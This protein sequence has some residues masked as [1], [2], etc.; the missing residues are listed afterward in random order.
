MSD[1]GIAATRAELNRYRVLE[2][3]DWNK[4]PSQSDKA[5]MAFAGNPAQGRLGRVARIVIAA[6]D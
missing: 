4:S 2:S 1:S 5:M 3:A 6:E